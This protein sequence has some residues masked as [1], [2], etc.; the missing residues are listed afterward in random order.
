VA[1][2]PL[3][4]VRVLEFSQIVA[5]PFA[6]VVL[7][8]FGA[9]VVKIEPIEGETYRS[10]G[11]IVPGEGKR[12]QS[13]NRGKRSIAVDLRSEQGQAL[14]H[15]IL[16]GFDVVTMNYRPGAPER[17]R[18]DYETLSAI[19]PGLIYC[20]MTGFGPEGPWSD[21]GATD[22]VAGSYSGLVAGNGK[23]NPDGSPGQL[24]PAVADY[25]TGLA[26]VAAIC[27]ALYHRRESGKGQRIDAALLMSALAIQDFDVMRHPITDQLLRDPMIEEINAVR[28]RGGDFAEQLEVRK[29]YRGSAAGSPRLF[30]SS[31]HVKDG[32]IT[33]GAL[34]KLTR[35]ASRR[36]LGIEHDNSDDEGFDPFDLENAARLE[37]LEREVRAT[38][39]TRTVAEWVAAF[40]AAG[41]P[42]APVHF[43]E[44]LSDD[45]Q[46]QGLGMMVDLD[47]EVTGPQRVVGPIV[48]M[49]VTPTAAR[50][51][52]PPLGRHTDEVLRECG[53]S[54]AEL[55]ELRAAGVVGG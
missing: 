2:G 36:V 41:V 6:G 40:Q 44:E 45:P 37:Q 27:A 4:G 35:D 7:S 53:V 38:F 15:R 51:P 22:I 29:K 3:A 20:S 26:S 28:A 49:S 1:D 13:L 16:P 52:S 10:A 25:S 48:R 46:V 19:H 9:D 54:E 33:I 18:I 32:T 39:R 31:Y 55:G 12:F 23:L 17:L 42:V 50:R 30:H 24:L 21:R 14:I 11:A 5:A 8:D 34:T 47:H 43:P